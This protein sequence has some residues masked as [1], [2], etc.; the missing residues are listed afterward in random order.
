MGAGS[1]PPPT[2]STTISHQN[3]PPFLRKIHCFTFDINL[4]FF[5]FYSRRI[6]PPSFS[7]RSEQTKEKG[8]KSEEGGGAEKGTQK[9]GEQ[10]TQT[11]IR[12]FL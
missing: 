10:S 12:H 5:S 7:A 11:R 2:D 1:P 9:G 4:V 6:P 8:R 3:Y